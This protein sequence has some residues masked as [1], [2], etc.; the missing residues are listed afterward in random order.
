MI[1]RSGDLQ[2]AMAS[3]ARPAGAPGARHGDLKV[4]ATVVA[5]AGTVGD[6]SEKP[7]QDPMRQ[8]PDRVP[9]L[10]AKRRKVAADTVEGAAVANARPR[11]GEERQR[12]PDGAFDLTAVERQR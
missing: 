6:D 10:I 12:Y 11:R 4:A 5:V 9:L 7:L 1:L 8:S 2:I 3:G